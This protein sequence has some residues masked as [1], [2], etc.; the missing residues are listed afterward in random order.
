MTAAARELDW[1]R[2]TTLGI[3]RTALFTRLPRELPA[4]PPAA[5]QILAGSIQSILDCDAE[6]RERAEPWLEHVGRLLL[7]LG[8]GQEARKASGDVDRP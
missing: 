8:G 7:A 6:I 2:V 4:L 1:N 3:E 5:R